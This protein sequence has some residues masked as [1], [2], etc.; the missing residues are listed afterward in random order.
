MGQINFLNHRITR[1]ETLSERMTDKKETVAVSNVVPS[2]P[3]KKKRRITRNRI[4]KSCKCC[5]HFKLKCDKASPCSNCVS[6]GT[7]DQCQYGFNK[8]LDTETESAV[9]PLPP[10]HSR[11]SIENKTVSK[12]VIDANNN[13]SGTISTFS[14]RVHLDDSRVWKV[15]E[16]STVYKSKYFYPFFTNSINDKFLSTETFGKIVISDDNFTRNEITKFNRFNVSSVTTTSE[17]LDLFPTSPPIARSQIETFFEWVHPIIPI[18]NKEKVLDKLDRIYDFLLSSSDSKATNNSKDIN[19]LDLLL[20]ISLFFCSAY[21]NVASGIIPDLLLCNKYY[22]AYQ[23]LLTLSEFPIRPVL[24]SL[25]SFLLINFVTDPN[26]VDATSYSPMLVRMGQQLGFH[27]TKLYPRNKELILLWHYILYLEGSA[28]VVSG[29]PFSTS[30]YLLTSIPLP[31]MNSKLFTNSVPIL[32]NNDMR[33]NLVTLNTPMEYTIG[34]FKINMVFKQIMDSTLI[35]GDLHDSLK[36]QLTEQVDTLYADINTLIQ[37]MRIHKYTH[38]EYFISTLQV[39]LY[40]LHLRYFALDKI[41]DHRNTDTD[42]NDTNRLK[43]KQMMMINSKQSVGPVKPRNI[44]WILETT[45]DVKEDVIPLSLLLLLSTLKRLVQKNVNNFAWYTRGSTVMQYLFVVL[46]DLYQ[47]PEKE[48][49]LKHFHYPFRATIDE[50]V[51]EIIKTSPLTFKLV[52]IEELLPLIELKL[53]PLW[54]R[55]DLYKFVLVKTVKNKVW[56]TYGP[57][58]GKNDSIKLARQQLQKCRLFASGNQNLENKKSIALEDCL[59]QWSSETEMLDP[60]Q[61]L[62]D[63]LAEFN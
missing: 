34:R 19:I 44:T 2:Q 30:D 31:T 42:E 29:F 4:I 9:N 55:S 26:M 20:I 48:Y 14:K 16:E 7:M 51:Q 47:N 27:K 23:H 15:S 61:I 53:T 10:H 28:S 46:R 58:W 12:T 25:Q 40:R 3:Q 13:K 56:Q 50:D 36:Q 62:I 22:V 37:S 49:A 11:S 39:F 6:R 45:Q 38:A 41:H 24:E 43:N 32:S 17:I 1:T 18:L 60:E 8:A 63:W 5:Y 52:L 54:K 59:A 21:C 57:M 35:V 33:K